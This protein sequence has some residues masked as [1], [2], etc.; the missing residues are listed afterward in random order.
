[1]LSAF[2][3]DQC[4]GLRCELAL[5]ETQLNDWLGEDNNS[6]APKLSRAQVL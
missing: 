2:L 6:R 1:M 3:R 4:E 5:L